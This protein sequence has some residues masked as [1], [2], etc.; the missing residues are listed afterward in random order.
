MTESKENLV[1]FSI[2]LAYSLI[3]ILMFLPALGPKMIFGTDYLTAGYPRRLLEDKAYEETG[4][5]WLY[6]QPYVF[7]GVPG[8]EA[9]TFGDAFYPVTMILRLLGIHADERQVLL[10][11]IHIIA[12]MVAIYFLAKDLTKQKKAALIAATAYWLT[13]SIFSLFY[14]GHEGRLIVNCLLPLVLLFLNRGLDG[15]GLHYFALAGITYGAAI[16]SPH[17]QMAYYLGMITTI[18]FIM[19]AISRYK[20]K[21]YKPI[22]Y[23]IVFAITAF[24]FAAPLILSLNKYIPFSL[25]AGAGRGYAWATSYSMPPEETLNLITPHFSGLL[26]NYWGRNFFKLHTEYI[27]ILPLILA[28]IGIFY[29]WKR[30]ETKFFTGWAIFALIF[31]WGG[32]TP[33]Y[34]VFYHL[35]WGVKKFRAPAQIFYTLAFSIAILAAIGANQLLKGIKEDRRLKYILYTFGGITFLIFL[36]AL[37]KSPVIGIGQAIS[38]QKIKILLGNISNLQSGAFL[39]FIFLLTSGALITLLIKKKITPLA[40]GIIGSVFILGDLWIIDHRFLKIVDPPEKHYAAD[41]IV[42]FL[43]ADQSRYRIF[44]VGS[45][46]RLEYRSGNYLLVHNIENCGGEHGNHLRRYQDFI[47]AEN[48]IMFRPSNFD[49][50]NMLSISNVKYAILINFDHSQLPPARPSEDPILR[51]IRTVIDSTRFKKAYQGYRY[52]VYENRKVVPRAVIYYDY[53]VLPEEAIISRIKSPDFDTQ[54]K[55]I[56]EEDIAIPRIAADY[57]PVRIESYAP[58]QIELS[59]ESDDDGILYLAD[60]Y[61]PMW[62]AAV[63]GEETKIYRANYTFRAIKAPKG[64]HKVLFWFDSPYINLGITLMFIGIILSFAIVLVT[65]TG[66]IKI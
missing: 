48:T 25:R 23:Y 26:N 54:K 9:A 15:K 21:V 62:H 22:V 7:G 33:I 56:L 20:L 60:N 61:Y 12:S 52:S 38:P 29:A 34:R 6:W 59:Y 5:F 24:L 32:H 51:S 36:L 47:G 57:T 39:A 53:E 18:F 41:E 1:I 42:R 28:F 50:Q 49:N 8:I 43:K 16:L 44:P 13:G 63:D 27:G 2:L 46:S 17:V 3:T 64:V 58:N 37:M 55:V 4:E 65:K 30:K 66:I 40:F 45:G 35:M 11:L 31:S 10:F 19:K 14:G